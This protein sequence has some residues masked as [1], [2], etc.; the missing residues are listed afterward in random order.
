MKSRWVTII[1]TG[2]RGYVVTARRNLVIDLGARCVPPDKVWFDGGVPEV[3][4]SSR[5]V[6]G[7][8]GRPR[9]IS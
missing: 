1:E 5:R 9:I 2:D 4:G 7:R 3:R 8:A 6:R